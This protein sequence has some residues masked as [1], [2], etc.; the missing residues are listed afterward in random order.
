MGIEDKKVVLTL[1][2]TKKQIVLVGCEDYN[3]SLVHKSY[4]DKIPVGFGEEHSKCTLFRV[5]KDMFLLK[6]RDT[7]KTF[8]VSR[9]PLRSTKGILPTT[10]REEVLIDPMH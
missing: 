4:W 9:T 3:Y 1:T 8:F 7:K 6:G 10:T 2:K 5:H